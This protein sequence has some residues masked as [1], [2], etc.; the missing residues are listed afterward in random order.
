MS[1]IFIGIDIEAADGEVP[2]EICAVAFQILPYF[3]V[4]EEFHRHV[5]VDPTTVKRTKSYWIYKHITGLS[6]STLCQYGHPWDEVLKSLGEF[7]KKYSTATVVAR[8]TSLEEKTL[9]WKDI[10]EVLDF[11]VSPYNVLWH[12]RANRPEN[13]QYAAEQYMCG[14]HEPVIGTEAIVPHCAR[15]DVYMIMMWLKAAYNGKIIS[16]SMAAKIYLR[17]SHLLYTMTPSFFI[18]P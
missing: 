17:L 18:F 14:L 13:I 8:D 11:I 7:R 1:T 9:G 16:T 4:F 15:A 2:S 10:H 6:F 3:Y 12:Q 5:Y